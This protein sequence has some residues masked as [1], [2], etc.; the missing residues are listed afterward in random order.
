SPSPE[1]S[2]PPELLSLSALS[3]PPPHATR[4]TLSIK[5]KVNSKDHFFQFMLY[6]PSLFYL[7]IQT[8]ICI[9]YYTYFCVHFHTIF[10][11]RK[12]KHISLICILFLCLYFFISYIILKTLF[13][14]VYIVCRLNYHTIIFSRNAIKF[15]CFFIPKFRRTFRKKS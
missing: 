8:S 15:F 1:L 10:K 12:F 2:P 7:Q 14:S 13:A 5:T 6:E 4:I 9:F 3:F 11:V